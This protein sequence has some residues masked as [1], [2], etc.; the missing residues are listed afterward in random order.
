MKLIYRRCIMANK[1]VMRYLQQ[2]EDVL[3]RNYGRYT[4][5]AKL[6]KP[7]IKNIEDDY[8]PVQ[9]INYEGLD[10][11][12]KTY[13]RMYRNDPKRLR[14][15][16]SSEILLSRLYNE[17]GITSATYYPVTTTTGVFEKKEIEMMASQSILDVPGIR[18]TQAVADEK[19]QNIVSWLTNRDLYSMEEL[20]ARRDEIAKYDKRFADDKFFGEFM[21]MHGA[22]NMC[23]QTDRTLNNFY[24]YN[25]GII[26]F[27][28]E[29]TEFDR[30]FMSSRDDFKKYLDGKGPVPFT[31][32]SLC[33][34]KKIGETWQDKM[35]GFGRILDS[36]VLGKEGDEFRKRLGKL[37]YHK[38][39][40]QVEREAGYPLWPDFVDRLGMVI[41]AAQSELC[42]Q[43][44]K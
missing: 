43:R 20:I 23:L 28:H 4:L 13:G 3:P 37:N 15:K 27:D 25:N 36:G 35:K 8:Q 42:P 22:D 18:P 30:F 5:P 19:M 2:M 7:V 44:T 34:V 29:R 38:F 1:D 24:T 21:L 32:H 14:A 9:K 12:I 11:F 40:A 26:V 41:S 10:M 6:V 31:P 16:F 33:P 17:L 39:V